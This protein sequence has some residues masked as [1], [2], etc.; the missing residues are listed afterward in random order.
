M[1]EVIGSSWGSVRIEQTGF[2]GQCGVHV[3]F[4]GESPVAQE[5]PGDHPESALGGL[6]VVYNS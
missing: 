3:C 5:R 2:G 6:P 4:S 1:N